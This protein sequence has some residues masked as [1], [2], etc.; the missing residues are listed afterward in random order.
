MTTDPARRPA[1]DPAP[2]RGPLV[3]CVD[4]EGD[5]STFE[6]EVGRSLM[7]NLVTVAEQDVAADC[8]GCAECGT[9]HVYVDAGWLAR[10]PAAE[11]QEVELLDGFLHTRDTSRLSCQIVVEPEL[12]GLTVELAPE[13]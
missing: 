8:G 13:E 4:R 12:D 1:L 7:W 11:E 10:L 5:A 2:G 6:A 9:C 3:T